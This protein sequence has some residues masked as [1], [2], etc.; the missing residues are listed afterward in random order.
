[1]AARR[2]AVKDVFDSIL[3]RKER[4]KL[5]GGSVVLSMPS[6]EAV[7]KISEYL[8]DPESKK[9][10]GY[11]V[12]VSA[13][14]LMATVNEN[15]RKKRTVGDF[16]SIILQTGGVLGELSEKSMSL[17]GLSQMYEATK[18]LFGLAEDMEKEA[19]DAVKEVDKLGDG[20][21]S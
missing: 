6:S 14:C 4:V 10:L 8:N 9:D 2:G 16:E 12:R 3:S 20:P 17:C 1:M 5:E 15:M 18:R 11:N 21:F 13:M 19:L 7:Y